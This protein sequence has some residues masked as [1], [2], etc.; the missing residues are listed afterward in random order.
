MLDELNQRLATLK[1]S[2]RQKGKLESQLLASKNSLDDAKRQQ[3]NLK[4]ILA[5]EQ[6]DVDALEGLSMTALFHAVL[7]SKEQKIQKERQE[8][9]AA[10]LKHDQVIDTVHTLTEDVQRL[11]TALSQINNVDTEYETALAEKADLLAANDSDVG[12]ELFEVTQQIADRT[13]DQKEIDEAISAGQSA[14]RA[15]E[16]IRTTLASAANW[17]TLDLIGGGMLTTMAKHSKI[18]SAKNQARMAQRKLLQFEEEL[19]DADQRL[20]VSLQID[21]FSKFADFFFD[22]LITDWIVQSKIETARTE[23]AKTISQVSDAIRQCKK[24]LKDVE[25]EIEALIEQKRKLIE[26]A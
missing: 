22:G 5:K 19:A 2:H 12:S 21:G 26:T 18:D 11:Q 15:I 13:A 4:H 6:A 23:C 25:S 16:E 20:Q 17:R 24:R 1:A 7:G 9:L 3:A 10:K 14:R 8:L